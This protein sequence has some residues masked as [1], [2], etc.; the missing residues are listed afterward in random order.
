MYF[1]CTIQELKPRTESSIL[2]S[3]SFQLHHTG[4]KTV[5]TEEDSILRFNFNCTI[6]ELKHFESFSCVLLSSNFNCT[7]Q[8]LKLQGNALRCACCPYFN[9]T[10]QELKPAFV[11]RNWAAVRYFNCTIQELKPHNAGHLIVCQ[12]NFNCTIQELK[13]V[14]YLRNYAL[15]QFQL[16]HTG[17]KTYPSPPFKQPIQYFNCTIQELKLG[18]SAVG[19]DMRHIS[20]APYRN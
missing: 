12:F 1:N 6:Q 20:I 11:I 18:R 13:R 19:G 15:F 17:I 7:I 3:T 8:E 4:I 9:C 16:H 14:R 2:A 5:T 10:I